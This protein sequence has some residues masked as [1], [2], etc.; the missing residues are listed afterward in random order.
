MYHEGV[1]DEVLAY[2]RGRG[3]VRA[4]ERVGVAVSG[5]ADSVALLRL[6]LE[7]RGELGVVLTVLH[8]H[9]G[10]RGPAADADQQFV[11]HLA[12]AHGLPFL[13]GAGDAP[14]QAREHGLSLEA[15]ARELRYAWF[16]RLL[17]EG[18]LDRVATAHTLDDQ[19][20]TVLLR[21]V[22]GAGTR[23]LAGIYPEMAAPAADGSQ[24]AA[25]G[26]GAT[27][28]RIVRPLL[29]A[30]RSQLREYLKTMGQDW[31]EDASNLDA[32]HARNR[33]RLQLLPLLEKEFNP[34]VARV[35]AQTAEIARDE[36]AFWQEAVARQLA[37]LE[38]KPAAA[39]E[40][41][42]SFRAAALGEHPA[43]LERRLV[44]ALGECVGL[45]LS[46][47]QVEGVRALAAGRG[48]R[49]AELPGEWQA[50]RAGGE[51]VI[52]RTGGKEAK[53]RRHAAAAGYEY[54]LPVPG[55]V[56][57]KELGCVIR[58]SLQSPGGGPA[59]YNAGRFLDPRSLAPELVVRNWRAG[60]RFW[61]AHN[62]SPKKVKSLLQERRVVEPERRLWPVV[63]SGSSIVWMRGFPASQEHRAGP[64]MGSALV[65]EELAIEAAQGPPPTPSSPRMPSER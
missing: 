50:A 13:A 7:L 31:R 55:E 34:G 26:G 63:A 4:G 65:I 47:E 27:Q 5:G 54:R 49:T 33:V 29:G 25:Q 30:R 37:A 21:L 56:R 16:W 17:R 58:A 64:E 60:D 1:V 57:V 12:A 28:G 42:V 20:E 32:A 19:A 44:R 38:I 14:V 11:E 22:R 24:H 48:G 45:R 53:G 62:K 18:R 35:L 2:I 36:E 8:F 51:I 3:L 41:G 6:L 39:G 59:G 61:P 52:R 9:H 43:A 10:I 46:L 40:A 23:G 15:A